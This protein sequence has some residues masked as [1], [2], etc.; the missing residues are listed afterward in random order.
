MK[1]QDL[2]HIAK[3]HKIQTAGLSKIQLIRKIQASEGNFDCFATA[4][5]GTCDQP[6]CLWRKE[7][8]SE[9]LH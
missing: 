1:L 3:D 9:S 8:F 7:C 5:M 4:T 2:R 6:D